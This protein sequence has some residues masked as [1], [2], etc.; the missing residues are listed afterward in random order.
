MQ[1]DDLDEAEDYLK[2][3]LAVRDEAPYGRGLG[4]RFDA[5]VSRENMARVYDKR[6][7]LLEAKGIRKRAGE[8][9]CDYYKVGI[10]HIKDT[11][12]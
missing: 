10:Y 1:I 4:P 11:K 7:N 3:A 8:I 12:S 5:A 6:G 2:K 9:C